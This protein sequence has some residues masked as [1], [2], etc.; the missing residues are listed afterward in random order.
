[1]PRRAVPAYPAANFVRQVLQ[2]NLGGPPCPVR[3]ECS[4]SAL[5]CS[6]SSAVHR[7]PLCIFWGKISALRAILRV[8]GQLLPASPSTIAAPELFFRS[9]PLGQA[10]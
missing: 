1:M 9:G 5:A 10:P 3:T 8:A 2:A 4:S 6:N 7:T